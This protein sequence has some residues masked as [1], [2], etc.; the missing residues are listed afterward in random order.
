[1]CRWLGV[2]RA[3]YYDW[4]EN[5][6][7]RAQRH[8]ALLERIIEIFEDSGEAYGS[9]RVYKKLRSEDWKCNHKLVERLMREHNISPKQK[10]KFK[11]TTDSRHNLP[12]APNVL[13]QNFVTEEPDEVWVSDITYVPTTQGWLYLCVFI[14]LYTRAVV[15]WSLS[16]TMKAEIVSDA[17]TMGIQRR[18]RAPIVAHSDRGSQYAS[19]LFREALARSDTIQSMSRKGNCWDNAVAESFFGALKTEL[20][21][22]NKWMSRIA[23]STAIFRYIEVFYNKKRLHSALGYITPEEKGLKGKKAA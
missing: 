11:S 13:E 9:P 8:S 2:C 23:T 5:H 14:D 17:F 1:M 10:A 15:G 20:I 21:Y 16:T 7:E 3:G 12:I 19:A 22:R 18:G 4:L 6:E